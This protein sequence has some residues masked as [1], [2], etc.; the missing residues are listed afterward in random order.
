MKFVP[1]INQDLCFA[2][3]IPAN[4]ICEEPSEEE[5]E[6]TGL[7]FYDPIAQEKDPNFAEFLNIE[8]FEQDLAEDLSTPSLEE[9][10]QD[11]KESINWGKEYQLLHEETLEIGGR[12]AKCLSVR[13]EENENNKNEVFFQKVYMLLDEIY[14]YQIITTTRA[15]KKAEYEPIFDRIVKSFAIIEDMKN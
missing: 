11:F 8:I 9:I 6:F 2:I 10:Y 1:Y 15:H 3:E 7:D 4:W 12:K 5:E 13:L 14:V